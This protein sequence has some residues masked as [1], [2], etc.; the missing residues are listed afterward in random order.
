MVFQWYYM[1]SI[2]LLYN[3]LV[4]NHL[5]PKGQFFQ[6]KHTATHS[7]PEL[8]QGPGVLPNRGD[9]SI[10]K[11]DKKNW[12]VGSRVKGGHLNGGTSLYIREIRKIGL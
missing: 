9:K 11:R 8:I 3:S 10:Y 5:F 7:P 2:I 1:I 4:D 6:S 12:A